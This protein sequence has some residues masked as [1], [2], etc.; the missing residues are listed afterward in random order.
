MSSWRG[1]AATHCDGIVLQGS[2]VLRR[3]TSMCHS[4]LVIWKCGLDDV[5]WL[6]KLWLWLGLI[7]FEA[8]IES[9][10]INDQRGYMKFRFHSLSMN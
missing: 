8:Q 3:S 4:L 6:G 1:S 9:A 2:A 10:Q 5:C 7:C